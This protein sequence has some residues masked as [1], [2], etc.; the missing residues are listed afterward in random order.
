L[1]DSSFDIPAVDQKENIPA[2][3]KVF[4]DETQER[5]LERLN[6]TLHMSGWDCFTFYDHDVREKIEIFRT[7]KRRDDA[8]KFEL[9]RIHPDECWP[10]VTAG[11]KLHGVEQLRLDQA[12]AFDMAM[13]KEDLR[14]SNA[15]GTGK[16][17][18]F[19]AIVVSKAL[20]EGIPKKKSKKLFALVIV[21]FPPLVEQWASVMRDM[22]GEELKTCI[23]VMALGADWKRNAATIRAQRPNIVVG[24][25]DALADLSHEG[26]FFGA[27]DVKLLVL[28]EADLLMDTDAQAN[29]RSKL[30]VTMS[31]FV[32]KARR[33][34]ILTSATLSNDLGDLAQNYLR[35]GY[36]GITVGD[37]KGAAAATL[38]HHVSE[39]AG[40]ADRLQHG[41]GGAVEGAQEFK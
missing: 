4:V 20:Y 9:R 2:V 5:D 12:L 6:S 27:R 41:G 30:Q 13:L 33:Q 39:N 34:T 26:K 19:A 11:L 15:N 31:E 36:M 32:T 10:T 38:E 14:V 8:V 29:F 28:D 24:T 35:K 7:K 21:P 16:S 25:P 22:V 1:R 23:R 18:V 3:D 40:E 37:R 17:L